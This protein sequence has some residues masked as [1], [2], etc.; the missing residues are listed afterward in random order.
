MSSM[1]RY[2]ES[3]KFRFNLE[4]DEIV[5]YT[6]DLTENAAEYHVNYNFPKIAESILT[7]CIQHECYPLK[8]IKF[9]GAEYEDWTQ[10][11]INDPMEMSLMFK[12]IMEQFVT[13]N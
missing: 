10:L 8:F 5:G 9:T 3:P 11:T 6:A 2:F 4:L 7:Y 12:V 1:A 13:K